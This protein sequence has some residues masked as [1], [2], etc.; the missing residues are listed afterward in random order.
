MKPGPEFFTNIILQLL[1]EP[2]ASLLMGILFGIDIQRNAPIYTQLKHVGLLHLVVLSGMNITL[3]GALVG[4]TAR[5]FGRF[6]STVISLLTIIFFIIFVGPKAPIV[7][8]GFMGSLTLV[9]IIYGRKVISIY[10]LILSGL[11]IAVLWPNWLSSVS[12]QLS[13][14]ATLG[15]ILFYKPVIKNA[16]NSLYGRIMNATIKDLRVSLAAQIFT[17][18][19]IFYYFREISLIAPIS[20]V[21]V[22]FLI[23]PLMIFGF[24]MSFLGAVNIVIGL[25]CGII[26]YGILSYMIV[27][28]KVLHQLPLSFLAFK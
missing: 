20:N 26:S 19:I 6:M 3:L 18:P 1:P 8:A 25:P 4:T 12:F 7:R 5:F 11:F 9:A 16:N 28:I 24:C 23:G 27:V 13:Y 15:I 10:L 2:Q 17:T 21:L 22:S 14:G